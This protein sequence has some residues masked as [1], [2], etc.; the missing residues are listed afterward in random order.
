MTPLEFQV[1]EQQQRIAQLEHDL[2]DA[3]ADIRKM[4][5]ELRSLRQELDDGGQREVA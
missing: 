3:L 1:N 4:R 2:D 5:Q